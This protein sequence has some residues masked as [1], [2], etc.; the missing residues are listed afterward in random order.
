MYMKYIIFLALVCSVF[1]ILKDFAYSISFDSTID[2]WF[3]LHKANP[4]ID[5]D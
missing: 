4:N 1:G 5:H 3:L 2:I